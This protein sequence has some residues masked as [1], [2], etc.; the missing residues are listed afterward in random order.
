MAA[1][2]SFS[3]LNY[4]KGTGQTA[5]VNEANEDSCIRIPGMKAARILNQESQRT[6]RPNHLD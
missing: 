5:P 6:H 3:L 1:R 2:H 4:F